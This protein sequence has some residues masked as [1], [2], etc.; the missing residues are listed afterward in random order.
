[1]FRIY[2]LLYAYKRDPTVSIT[3]ILSVQEVLTHLYS[4]LLHQM[5][6][7]FLDIKYINNMVI[8]DWS[9]MFNPYIRV[10]IYIYTNIRI[11]FRI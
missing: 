11:L 3:H 5:G 10:N 4:T 1:M 7:D 9:Y 2:T 6:Q 8:F